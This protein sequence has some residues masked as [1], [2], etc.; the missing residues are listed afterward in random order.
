MPR[1]TTKSG[2]SQRAESA[3]TSDSAQSS[4]PFSRKLASWN[5]L[6]LL[7]CLGGKKLRRTVSCRQQDDYEEDAPWRRDHNTDADAAVRSKTDKGRTGWNAL[8]SCRAALPSFTLSLDD[9]A[10]F[11][12][13]SFAASGKSEGAII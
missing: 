12:T 2:L 10:V 4:R 8:T 11:A 5:L 3:D 7:T 1:G 13:V 6:T 9:A